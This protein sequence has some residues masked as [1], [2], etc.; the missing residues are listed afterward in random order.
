MY[1]VVPYLLI[2]ITN[3][4]KTFFIQFWVIPLTDLTNICILGDG[5]RPILTSERLLVSELVNST[6][7]IMQDPVKS[8]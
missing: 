4:I 7:K 6:L 2:N 8:Q 5:I 1:H 3:Y